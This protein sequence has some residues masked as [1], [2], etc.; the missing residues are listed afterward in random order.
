MRG[1]LGV[2]TASTML[3][4]CKSAGIEAAQVIGREKVL[5]PSQSRQIL[6][7]RNFDLNE[8]AKIIDFWVNKGGVGKSHLSKLVATFIATLGF[9][10]LYIDTDSQG[11]ATDSFNINGIDEDTPVLC[12]VFEGKANIEECIIKIDEN[13]DLMPSTIINQNISDDLIKRYEVNF[14]KVFGKV[15]EPIRRNYDYIVIDSAPNLGLL[16]ICITQA[17]D[18][19]LLLAHPHK[20][21][22]KGVH[23][24]M[25]T[26]DELE[27]SFSLKIPRRI[28]FNRYAKRNNLT[29]KVMNNLMSDYEDLFMSTIVSE[30]QEIAN[31]VDYNHN[32]FVK[33]KYQIPDPKDSSKLTNV[34]YKESPGELAELTKA[35]LALPELTLAQ[36]K[37]VQQ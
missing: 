31:A 3:K 1:F 4:I 10:V 9:K 12:D 6:E 11:N 19:T 24:T 18:M 33:T 16:N 13:F 37:Q 17:A 15:L 21:S 2:E 27:D 5:D 25:K 32:F 35:I 30:R 34:D 7:H 8:S 36:D 29:H 26:I 20:F 23:Q 28:I 14:S 22:T